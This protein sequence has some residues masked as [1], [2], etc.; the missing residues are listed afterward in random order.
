MSPK[1]NLPNARL[2]I[3]E[4]ERLLL[5]TL[6]GYLESLGFEVARAATLAEAHRHL[7]EAD[8][9]AAIL[10]VGLPDGDGLSLLERAGSARSVVISAVPDEQRYARRGVRHALAKPIDLAELAQ[11]LLRLLG[12]GGDTTQDPRRSRSA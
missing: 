12:R 4:D 8:V 9:D 11:L 2:L 1:R 3:A 6:G 10:D 5:D 7:D